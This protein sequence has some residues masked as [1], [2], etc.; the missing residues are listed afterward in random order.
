M[1]EVGEAEEW[2]VEMEQEGEG[3]EEHGVLGRDAA[4]AEERGLKQVGRTKKRQWGHR[5]KLMVLN[6]FGL[7]ASEVGEAFMY[8]A[9]SLYLLNCR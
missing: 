3:K 6:P 7:L 5:K 8:K 4:E 1:A 9:K 2:R